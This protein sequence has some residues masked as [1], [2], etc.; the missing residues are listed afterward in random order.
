MILKKQASLH[1]GSAGEKLVSEY[2]HAHG[3]KILT[4]N[5]R[6][7]GGEIDLIARKDDLIVCVEVKT[8][9]NQETDMAELVTPWQQQR[10][11]HAAQM[12]LAKNRLDAVTCRFDVALVA[13]DP[14]PRLDY[15]PD[16]FEGV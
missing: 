3:F 6:I 8:R 16:A 13:M 15:I 5:M 9:T 2:L 11:I 14:E 10:I 12:F 4:Q 1:L 7:Q